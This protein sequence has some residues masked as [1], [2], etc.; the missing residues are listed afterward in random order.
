[1]GLTFVFGA[2][3]GS[4]I[5]NRNDIHPIIRGYTVQRDAGGGV[6]G[7]DIGPSSVGRGRGGGGGG[8]VG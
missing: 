8:S 1:M 7:R 6:G 4:A 3:D 2:I 5:P